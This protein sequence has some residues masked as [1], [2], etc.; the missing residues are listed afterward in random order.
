[1]HLGNQAA[2]IREVHK[3]HGSPGTV[4][5]PNTGSPEW[6]GPGKG[7]KTHS[8]LGYVP[9]WSTQESEQLIPGK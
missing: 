6:F 7:T 5:S 2:G 4:C 1:M 3:T 8:P 9:L